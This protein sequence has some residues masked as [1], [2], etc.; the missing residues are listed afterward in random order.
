MRY[1]YSVTHFMYSILQDWESLRVLSSFF[2][3]GPFMLVSGFSLRISEGLNRR[4]ESN[5]K[6]GQHNWLKILSNPPMEGYSIELQAV[7]LNLAR[8]FCFSYR[9]ILWSP[10]PNEHPSLCF[11]AAFTTS[12][13][14][15]GVRGKLSARLLPTMVLASALLRLLDW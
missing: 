4:E 7:F 12:S 1:Q 2:H 3:T 11:S 5:R 14:Q 15:T 8:E 6:S 13:L 10:I 9:R